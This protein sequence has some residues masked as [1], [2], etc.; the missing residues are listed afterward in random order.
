MK[1]NK[2]VSLILSAVIISA[3]SGTVG[4]VKTNKEVHKNKVE[5]TIL[6]ADRQANTGWKNENGT[7]YY[8]NSNGTMKK[9]WLLDNGKWYYLNNSGAM[10]TGW[11][12]INGEWFYFNSNG[13]MKKWWLLENGEWYYLNSSGAMV[14]GWNKLNGTWY[15]FN[16]NGSMKKWWLLENGQWYY[17]NSSGAMVTGWNKINGKWYYFDS[18]GS[19][20]KGWLKYKG[21]SYYLNDLGA[22]EIGGDTIDGVTYNFNSNGELESNP[23]VSNDDSAINNIINYGF[24]GG[25]IN[26][27]P[28]NILGGNYLTRVSKTEVKTKMFYDNDLSKLYDVTIKQNGK[29]LIFKIYN[30]DGS[31]KT[32][33]TTGIDYSNT[34]G[35]KISWYAGLNNSNTY[36]TGTNNVPNSGLA[37]G[38]GGVVYSGSIG[39]GITLNLSANPYAGYKDT[40]GVYNYRYNPYITA[41]LSNNPNV[42]LKGELTNSQVNNEDYIT[43]YN[44]KTEVGEIEIYNATPYGGM[45]LVGEYTDY[46]TGETSALNL[47]ASDEYFQN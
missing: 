3:I 25:K 14:T 38:M 41:T 34:Y 21:N 10:V 24:I 15:Y 22:M 19:M 29:N 35:D 32:E 47:M 16:S 46:K 18:N 5:N 44:G 45:E 39:N 28:V 27:E 33:F 6:L 42:T 37:L 36:L 4:A 8:Y 17:L 11:D 9:G 30:N 40:F 7:W 23:V 43:L 12:K 1:K 13:S 26:N 20:K 2:V 31:I